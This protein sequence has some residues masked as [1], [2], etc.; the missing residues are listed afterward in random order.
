M[1]LSSVQFSLIQF[2]LKIRVNGRLRLFAGVHK[3]IERRKNPRAGLATGI[4]RNTQGMD[5]GI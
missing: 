3:G 2:G 4:A 1:W 5:Q